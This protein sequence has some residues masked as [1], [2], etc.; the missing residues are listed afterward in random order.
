V[1]QEQLK[2]L[3]RQIS[4]AVPRSEHTYLTEQMKLQ[5][6][7]AMLTSKSCFTSHESL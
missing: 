5:I 3:S 1:E 6:E 2:D 7:E 4:L